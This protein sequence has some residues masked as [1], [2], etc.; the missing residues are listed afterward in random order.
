MV[1]FLACNAINSHKECLALIWAGVSPAT[2]FGEWLEVR[3]VMHGQPI[4]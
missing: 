1:N 2:P 3:V 4:H